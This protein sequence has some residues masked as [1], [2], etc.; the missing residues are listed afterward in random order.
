VNETGA[1]EAVADPQAAAWRRE[2]RHDVARQK[3]LAADAVDALE[4]DT[5]EAKQAAGC[6]EPEI[7]VAALRQGL[8]ARRPALGHGPAG[9]IELGDAQFRR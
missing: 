4:A 9:V 8:Y 7:A 1:A 2:Q 3:A 5:V 6:G